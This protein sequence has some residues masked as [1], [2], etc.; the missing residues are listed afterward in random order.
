MTFKS[1]NPTNVAHRSVDSFHVELV[2]ETDGKAMQRSNWPAMLREIS[3]QLFSSCDGLV[4][5]DLVQTVVDL[6]GHGHSSTERF[7][8]FPARQTFGCKLLG[9]LCGFQAGDD[10][11]LLWMERLDQSPSDVFL[12]VDPVKLIST[13]APF[14]RYIIFTA[15]AVSLA[16]ARS[17]QK[18]CDMT[19]DCC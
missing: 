19:T 3:I 1:I 4:G 15:V 14:L 8:D 11:F 18:G 2:L 5:E 12:F 10:I 17:C 7:C 13:Q 9:Q 6:M 16:S